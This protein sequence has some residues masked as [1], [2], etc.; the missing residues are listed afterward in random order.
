MKAVAQQKYVRLEEQRIEPI[1]CPKKLRKLRYSL[2]ESGISMPKSFEDKI[3]KFLNKNTNYLIQNLSGPKPA[4]CYF[5][6]PTFL[7]EDLLYIGYEDGNDYLG[8]ILV[9]LTFSEEYGVKAE[10]LWDSKAP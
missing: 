10:V 5:L 9:K 6:K 8:E 2:M 1:S 7:R 4:N 3:L